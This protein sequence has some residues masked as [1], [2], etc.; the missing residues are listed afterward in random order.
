MRGKLTATLIDVAMAFGF[1]YAFQGN[2]YAVN[3]VSYMLY[4]M[5][6]YGL[7][8]FVVGISADEK[9]DENISK[10]VQ[11]TGGELWKFYDTITDVAYIAL[12]AILGWYFSAGCGVM[13]LVGKAAL[14]SAADKAKDRIEKSEAAQ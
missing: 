8:L 13:F 4:L 3:G 1:Y 5:G 10:L 12:P 7:L 2:V 14:K 11:T 6:G 9:H